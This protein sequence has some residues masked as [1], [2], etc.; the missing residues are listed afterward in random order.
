MRWAWPLPR[1]SAGL[2][3]SGGNRPAA[4]T[5]FGGANAS[6]GHGPLFQVHDNRYKI[7]GNPF[8][9]DEIVFIEKQ[10]SRPLFGSG[11]FRVVGHTFRCLGP[12]PASNIQFGYRP[13]LPGSA[14]PSGHSGPSGPFFQSALFNTRLRAMN[15]SHGSSLPFVAIWMAKR[16]RSQH[17]HLACAGLPPKAGASVCM[18]L[19]SAFGL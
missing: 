13:W 11:S 1:S 2:R 17:P 16:K 18:G 3:F 15:S 4:Q 5:R 8:F 7:S 14:K 19:L 10:K 12:K 6:K 9:E